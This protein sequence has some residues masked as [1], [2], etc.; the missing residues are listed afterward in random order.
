[1]TTTDQ[2][3]PAARTD[4]SDLVRHQKE[5]LRLGYERLAKECIDPDTGE[6]AVKYSWLHRLATYQTVIPPDLP[7]LRGLAAGLQ[8]PFSLVQE[9][10]GSQFFGIDTLWSED[11]EVRAMVHDYHELEPEDQE[12][13]RALMS[14]WRKLKRD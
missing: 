12:K 9:A 10:A 8:V 6:Q 2:A 14:S 4:L 11:G 3:N 7:Q 5:A 13:A 1:M